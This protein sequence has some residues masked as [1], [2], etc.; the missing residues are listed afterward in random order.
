MAALRP[1]RSGT[2]QT[3]PAPRRPGMAKPEAGASV[4][5][6]TKRPTGLAGDDT[7]V[8]GVAAGATAFA[9]SK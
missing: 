8:S 6:G 7:P 3:V 1:P 9:P 5:I 2:I 4:S